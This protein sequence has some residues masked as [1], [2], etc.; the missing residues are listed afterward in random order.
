MLSPDFSLTDIQNYLG[1]D[2]KFKVLNTVGDAIT[3]ALQFCNV[4]KGDVVITQAIGPKMALDAVLALGAIPVLIDSEATNWNISAMTIELVINNCVLTYGVRPKAILVKHYMGV[5]AFMDEVC[6]V[7]HR[8]HIPLIEDCIGSIGASF[9]GKP[10]GTMG[11]YSIFSIGGSKMNKSGLGLLVH[12]VPEFEEFLQRH[13]DHDQIEYKGELSGS[14]SLQDL[15]NELSKRR[16][17]YDLYLNAFRKVEGLSV[18]QN[19]LPY[20]QPNYAYSALIV[21]QQYFP[22][23]RDDVVD[24]IYNAGY[25]G[26]CAFPP[27][28]NTLPQFSHLTFYGCRVGSDICTNGLVLPS[29]STLTDAD[30][31]QIIQIVLKCLNL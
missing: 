31:N 23:K 26:V 4:A 6:A 15:R 12:D 21:Q 14:Y 11:Q 1:K 10:C 20:I 18:F 3:T 22:N 5:P 8:H 17:I 29:H 28:L 2:V 9:D 16:H 30:V 25:Q 13:L 19:R 27:S 7:A 24:A